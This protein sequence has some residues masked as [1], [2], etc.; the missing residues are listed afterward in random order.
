MFFLLYK[1]YR[2]V[3]LAFK[4]R[5]KNVLRTIDA[6]LRSGRSLIAEHARLNFEPS[7]YKDSTGRDLLMYT[8]IRA[9]RFDRVLALSPAVGTKLVDAGVNA[10]P[11]R[12]ARWFQ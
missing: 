3:A 1:L 8:Y 6:M 2:T 12:V 11:G 5:H 7:T 9:P 4:K 10:G